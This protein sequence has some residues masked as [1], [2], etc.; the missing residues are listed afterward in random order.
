[1]NKNVLRS[2]R[3]GSI[4]LISIGLSILGIMVYLD[5]PKMF[6]RGYLRIDHWGIGEII[7]PLVLV[8]GF[9]IVATRYLSWQNRNFKNELQRLKPK[10]DSILKGTFRK[11]LPSIHE[12]RWELA[13]KISRCIRWTTKLK[14]YE[15]LYDICLLQGM[16]QLEKDPKAVARTVEWL[17]EQ[18][19][20]EKKSLNVF[21]DRARE[22]S[23]SEVNLF[24]FL[25]MSLTKEGRFVEPKGKILMRVLRHE[26]YQVDDVP[27]YL[28]R[29]QSEEMSKEG[30]LGAFASL[31]VF[32][33]FF[34][35]GVLEKISSWSLMGAKNHF[36]NS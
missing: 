36:K 20:P 11:N 35:G 14:L 3:Y 23:R 21:E 17:R 13:S 1:M 12:L 22:L 4:I 16:L 6:T 29:L 26:F 30:I 28:E 9:M 8:F 32:C 24:R 34:G 18:G 10:Y 19:Y 2:E 25:G 33:L 5:M 31:V 15:D 27:S 7:R